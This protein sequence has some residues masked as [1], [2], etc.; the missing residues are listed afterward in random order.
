M[1]ILPAILLQVIPQTDDYIRI[2]PILVLAIFGI[3]VM[4]LDPLVDE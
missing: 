2:L 3:G 1:T 4:V